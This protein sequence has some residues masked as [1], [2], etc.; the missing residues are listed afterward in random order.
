VLAMPAKAST[1]AIARPTPVAAAIPIQCGDGALTA[2]YADGDTASYIDCTGSWDGNLAPN[3]AAALV[4]IINLEFG[5]DHATLVGKT[6]DATNPWTNEPGSVNSGVL[7]F[8]TPYGGLFVVGLH[9]GLQDAPVYPGIPVAG[10]G[11]FSLYLFDGS[12]HGGV[13]SIAFDTQGIALDRQGEGR[14]LSHAALYGG[15]WLPIPEVT[16]RTSQAR[17]PE[18]GVLALLAASLLA[19]GSISRRRRGAAAA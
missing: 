8:G 12:D 2:T 11:D 1:S 16:F 5:L 10:G 6:G 18:P 3:T 15:Q 14:N 9:G 17:V 7:N 13:V 19:A 4:S